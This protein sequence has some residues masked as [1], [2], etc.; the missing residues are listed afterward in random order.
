MRSPRIFAALLL[1]PMLGC[2]GGTSQDWGEEMSLP[3]PQGKATLYRSPAVDLE[4]AGKV[5]SAMVDGNYN[6]ASGLPEQVDRID[7]TLTLRLGND[8]REWIDELKA[9]GAAFDGLF[10]FQALANHLSRA[11]DGEEVRIILCEETLDK[12]IHT[13]EWQPLGD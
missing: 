11:L 1:L 10:H 9:E 6:F 2:G 8:N 5:L 12:P 13:L 3:I 7:G 4:T